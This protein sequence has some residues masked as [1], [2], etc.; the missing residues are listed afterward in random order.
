MR[1]LNLR[2]MFG[3]NKIVKE[4]SPQEPQLAKYEIIL[5]KEKIKQT[6]R[7]TV[8]KCDDATSIDILIGGRHVAGKIIQSSETLEN[9]I[10]RIMKDV[11][12]R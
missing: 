8:A 4:P 12:I 7:E 5:A 10:E 9:A 11:R 3:R 1:G 2:D 6:I